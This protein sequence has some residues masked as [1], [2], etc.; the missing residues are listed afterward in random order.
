MGAP[1]EAVDLKRRRPSLAAGVVIDLCAVLPLPQ[2]YVDAR[3]DFAAVNAIPSV[4]VAGGGP[5][6]YQRFGVDHRWDYNPDYVDTLA[7]GD[8][9]SPHLEGLDRSASREEAWRLLAASAALRDRH[10]PDA[11]AVFA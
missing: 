4:L 10:F 3:N 2:L 9:P 11:I 1:F 5:Q 7:E 8:A 6:R